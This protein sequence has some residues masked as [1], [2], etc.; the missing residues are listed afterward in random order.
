M[1]NLLA[2]LFHDLLSFLLLYK[3][4]GLFIIAL[5]SS[6]ALPIPAST[7]LAAA[8][9]YESQGYMNIYAVLGI[10]LLGSMLGDLI[11][12][13]L[14]R[15][16]GEKVLDNFLFF[17][18]LFRSHSYLKVKDYIIDFA[19]SLIFFSRFLTELSPVTNL[20]AGLSGV[21][22]KKFFTFALLGEIIY[23]I[24]YGLTGFLLGSQW[25]DNIGFFLKA[26]SIILLLGLAV[27][28]IQVLLYKK[29]TKNT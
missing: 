26:G 25:E 2:P 14:A 8:G 19:P 16:Y 13:L 1:I 22:L 21:S 20:L 5:T 7:A 11:G 15:K 10:T 12:Y 23:T 17:R 4:F 18:H 28:L 9:G 3:Y 29:R 6:I 27:N 24:M